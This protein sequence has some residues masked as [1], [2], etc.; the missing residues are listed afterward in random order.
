MQIA[1][2]LQTTELPSDSLNGIALCSTDDVVMC[3]WQ[4]EQTDK[5]TYVNSNNDVAVDLL[6]SQAVLKGCETDGFILVTAARASVAQRVH[7]PVWRNAQLL[8]KRSWV[9]VL[10]GM[11]V[12]RIF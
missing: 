8:G 3:N 4:S 5:F 1:S 6:N 12:E 10:S 2:H 9:A 7:M 11:Q